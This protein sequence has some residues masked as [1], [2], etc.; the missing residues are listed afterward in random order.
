M[1]P[2][3]YE[4]EP[5]G[6]VPVADV[7]GAVVSPLDTVTEQFV[8]CV[9]LVTVIVFDP[10]VLYEVPNEGPEPDDGVPPVAVHEYV[11]VPPDEVKPAF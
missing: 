8:L 11:P 3:K 4:P 2:N 9:P 10:V 6:V 7:V 1:E 5:G